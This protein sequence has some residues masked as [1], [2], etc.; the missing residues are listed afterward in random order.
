[1]HNDY[2]IFYD[3]LIGMTHIA[4]HNVSLEEIDEILSSNDFLLETRKD[5]SYVGYKQISNGR[6]LA[7]VFRKKS[8]REYFIITAYDVEEN[9]LRKGIE[10]HE[11]KN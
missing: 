6:F 8:K 9:F 7:V 10:D 1:M 11:N 5:K 2:E 4:K 3:E